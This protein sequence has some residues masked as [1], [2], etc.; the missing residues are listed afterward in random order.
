MR[1]Q[2]KRKKHKVLQA[3]AFSNSKIK[4]S[5]HIK[6]TKKKQSDSME[7]NTKIGC[8]FEGNSSPPSQRET[9]LSLG[10]RKNNTATL[11]PPAR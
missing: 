5:I 11:H 9:G 1:Q 7:E 3:A 10:Q 8:V 2:W 4:T 6:Y